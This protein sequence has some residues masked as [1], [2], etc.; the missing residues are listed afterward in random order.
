ME[1]RNKRNFNFLTGYEFTYED[2]K[3]KEK[4]FSEIEGSNCVYVDTERFFG[5]KENL[6]SKAKNFVLQTK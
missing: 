3:G 1:M 4:Y 5:R 2:E 6:I